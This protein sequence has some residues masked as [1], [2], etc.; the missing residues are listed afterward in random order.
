MT[1]LRL[2]CVLMMMLS[3]SS[4]AV[5]LRVVLSDPIGDTTGRVDVVNVV[6]DFET[7][8]GAYT[9]RLT[10]DSGHPFSGQFRINLNLFNPDTG[11]LAKDPGYFQDNIRDFNLAYSTLSVSL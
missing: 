9:I 10:A 2:L 6:M 3:S 1:K 8:T 5:S 4:G 7:A 11:I